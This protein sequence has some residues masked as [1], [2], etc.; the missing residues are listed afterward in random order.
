[1]HFLQFRIA[2]WEFIPREMIAPRKKKQIISFLYQHVQYE[3][4][5]LNYGTCCLF[6]VI[7][8]EQRIEQFM[9][10][11]E[12]FDVLELA[13]DSYVIHDTLTIHYANPAA[14]RYLG[15]KE[16]SLSGRYYVITWWTEN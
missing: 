11:N 14:H 2:F 3:V 4:R 5:V 10:A 13:E 7:R 9:S 16:K 8:A 6:E 1:M 12:L 15:V